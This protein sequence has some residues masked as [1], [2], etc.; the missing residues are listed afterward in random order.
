MK[1]LLLAALVLSAC[2]S[3][4]PQQQRADR[5]HAQSL[6]EA[7]LAGTE[8]ACAAADEKVAFG[9]GRVQVVELWATWCQPCIRALPMWDEMGRATGTEILAVSIDDEREAP[10]AFAKKHGI[11][12]PILWDPLAR[13]LSASVQLPGVVPTTLV[14]GCDGSVRHVHQGFGDER[15]VAEV[16]EQVRALR[17]ESTCADPHPLARCAP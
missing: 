4:Q 15:V 9:E 12:L 14:V 16:A 8:L 1:R 13:T 10:L 17:A 11:E 7:T 2:A 6:A 3:S 5:R